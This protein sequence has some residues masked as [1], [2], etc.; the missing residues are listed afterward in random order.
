MAANHSV[1]YFELTKLLSKTI[2]L[3]YKT[4]GKQKRKFNLVNKYCFKCCYGFIKLNNTATAVSPDI[5]MLA[6]ILS[7][8]CSSIM[9]R[10][11]IFNVVS[12]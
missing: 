1:I 7:T 6:F 4:K 10:I 3:F 9:Y 5:L 12:I 2:S 11:I 8:N